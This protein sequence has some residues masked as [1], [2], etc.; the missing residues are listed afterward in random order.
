MKRLIC[1]ISVFLGLTITAGAQKDD[2][3]MWYELGLEKKLSKKW[4]I[5]ME[6]EFRTRN[7]TKTADRWSA[8]VSAEYKIAKGLKASAGYNILFDNNPEDLTWNSS[9][10]PKKWTPSYWGTRHRFN[11]S[12]TGSVDWGRLKLSLRERWQY[13][14]RP[15]AKDKKYAFTYD[16]NDYLSGYRLDPVNSKNKR[17]LRSRLQASYDIAHWKFDPTASA[18][19]FTDKKGIQKMR[20]QIGIDYKVRKQHVFSLSYR[21]Q[22]VNSDDDDNDVNS[23]LIGLGYKYKF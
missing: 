8:G 7:N 22:T 13:T 21:Y 20:Y 11:V 14:Y 4:N 18:E 3:G 17:M 16:D 15:E 1:V 23:H 19:M 12:M 5:S 6:G 2:F 9:N 10:D